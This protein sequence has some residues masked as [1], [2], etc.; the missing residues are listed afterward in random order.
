MNPPIIAFFNNKGGVGKT[1]L[2]YHLAWM[3]RDLGRK[4]IAADLD[5][6]ANLTSAFL[7]EDR[8]EQ[9]W[10]DSQK[11]NTIFRCIQPLLRGIGDIAQP[12]LETI[13]LDLH[14]LIGDL[15]L[16]GFEDELSSQW[17][18]C[19]DGKERAFRVI[20][21]FWR[22]LHQSAIEHQADLVLMDLGPNL[23]AINRAALIAADYIV[24]PL[25]PDLFS[26]QGLKNLGP[27]VKRW[28]GEWQDRFGRNPVPDLRLPPG[29]MQPIGYVIL[30]H[31]IRF[32]RPV[33]AFE[34]WMGRIPETYHSKVIQGQGEAAVSP[35]KDEHCLALLKHYQSLMP[36]AQEAR[37]PMFHL[38]PA[39][40]AIGAH[41]RAVTGVYWDFKALADKIGDRTKLP[42][43]T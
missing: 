43:I 8:L 25:A 41:S 29:K 38:K 39:D 16:S 4:V 30:Q 34:R 6:Q 20:S 15:T 35:G 14:L 40:G 17:P 22:L 31:A 7:E 2:V 24:I 13:D 37:K 18:D 23:G 28:R 1:S 21:A 3:Y 19:L 42:P 32:D 27:T 9:I 12:E 26:L 33:R 10:E 36:M 11:P 5:P